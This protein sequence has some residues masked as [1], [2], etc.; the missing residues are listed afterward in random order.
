M[1]VWVFFFYIFQIGSKKEDFLCTTTFFGFSQQLESP[2]SHQPEILW[3]KT[4]FF[5]LCTSSIHPSLIKKSDFLINRIFVFP[6]EPSFAS[7]FCFSKTEISQTKSTFF[8]IR[9]SHPHFFVTSLQLDQIDEESDFHGLGSWE[10][11]IWMVLLH[12]L[13]NMLLS[14]LLLMFFICFLNPENHENAFKT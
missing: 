11:H 13:I 2:F 4:T 12:L 10:L 1:F 8:S 3:A 14:L 9:P 5:P 6:E 7:T